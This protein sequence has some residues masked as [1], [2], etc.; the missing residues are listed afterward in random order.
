M[1]T[2]LT[3]M[4]NDFNYGYTENGAVKHLTTMD[5]VLDLFAMGGAYRNRSEADCIRLFKDAFEENDVLALKCLFYLRDVRGGQGERRFFRVCMEWL[6]ENY[7]ERVKRLI[8]YIPEF[9]RYDDLFSLFD[10]SVENDVMSLI[11]KQLVVDMDSK[12]NGISLIAKWMPSENASSQLTKARAKRIRNYLGITSKEYRCMLSKLRKKINVLET[13]MSANRWDEIVFDKIPSKAGLKYKNAFARRDL[14]AEKYR[15][16]VKDKSKSVNAGTL[17]PYEIAERAFRMY[18]S[19]PE[20]TDRLALQ[21]Y[22]EN[23]PDYYQG[24]EENG[25]AIVDVSG[26]MDGR[27]MAAA[28]S[29]GAYVAERGHGPFANHFITFSENP[30]LV[31]FSGID[32]VDKILGARRADWGMNTNIE[33]VFEMLLSVA[34]RKHTRPEDIPTRLYIFSD[35]EFDE[36]ITSGPKVVDRYYYRFSSNRYN[37]D[38]EGID[39]LFEQIKKKWAKFGY[40]L[41]QVIF[42]NLNSR[43]N[44]IPAI[45]EGFSYISGFSPVMIDTIL[46]GKDGRDLMLEKLNSERYECIH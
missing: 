42:W 46:S 11:T 40:K 20:D 32:I 43:N 19:T 34:L 31:E 18:G 33:A 21:K 27:P 36:C 17:Y 25:L 41:P 10:T 37:L 22:W 44:N 24:R 38:R 1:N 15:A 2:F 45:G 16:F 39:T 28:I 14:I 9:G 13:L 12:E 6:A 3:E 7:P 26:S 4:K 8:K 30:Q 5:H 35:M 29:L 23:L